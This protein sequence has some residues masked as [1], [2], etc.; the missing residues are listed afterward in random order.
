MT[1]AREQLTTMRVVYGVMV[2]LPIFYAVIA[3][4]VWRGV[5]PIEE[6]RAVAMGLAIVGIMLAFL[7]PV[8]RLIFLPRG[9]QLAPALLLRVFFAQQLVTWAL[10]QLTVVLGLTGSVLSHDPR[11]TL[12]C[13]LLCLVHLV[14]YR[15]SRKNLARFLSGQL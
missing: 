11:W 10:C 1:P 4:L 7:V 8:A 13:A 6:R 3:L 5:P 9:R 14:R 2:F 12:G 15:P